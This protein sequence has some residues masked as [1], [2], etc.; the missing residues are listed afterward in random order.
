M[1]IEI[2]DSR[3]SQIV[4]A[5]ATIEQIATGFQFTEGP[6]WHPYEKHLT[7]SD[8]IGNAI[9]RWSATDGLR[10]FRRPSQMTNGNTYDSQGRILSCEHASSRVTRSDS[11]GGGYEIL[12]SHY[13]GKELNSPND[14]VVKSDGSIYFTDPPF[15]RSAPWGVARAQELDFPGVYRLEPESGSL[16]LLVDDFVGPNG[17][18]LSLDE[19]RLF[20]NDTI[21]GHIRVFDV[22]A[23]GKLAN[24]RLWTDVTGEANGVPDGM[25]VDTAGNLFSCGP[26]GVHIF[27]ANANDL[28]VIRAPEGCANFTWGDDDLCTLYMTASTSVYR[29][30]VKVPGRQLF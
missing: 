19:K 5:D 22:Q 26:G 15:G 8:I 28:G 4:A 20:V 1:P 21:Q 10:D 18:C 6:A 27:D 14:I 11:A 13:A 25:K 12:A 24:G 2:R 7:F 30:R 29:V 23:D 16:T 17:L 9:H 3:I